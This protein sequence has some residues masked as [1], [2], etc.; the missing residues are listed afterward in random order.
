MTPTTIVI[1]EKF[2]LGYNW[3]NEKVSMN[4]CIRMTI[5]PRPYGHPQKIPAMG[6]VKPC[7]HGSGLGYG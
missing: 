5:G 4:I 6:R 1:I 2:V 3:D 7:F